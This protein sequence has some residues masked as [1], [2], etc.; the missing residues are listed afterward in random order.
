MAPFARKVT[1]AYGNSKWLLVG[2][3][4]ETRICLECPQGCIA[5]YKEIQKEPEVP[6]FF[7]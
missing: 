3:L 2:P 6:V 5:V 1:E 4:P 7:L